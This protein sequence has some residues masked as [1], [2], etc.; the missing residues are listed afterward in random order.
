MSLSRVRPRSFTVA[1][2]C[3]LALAATALSVRTGAAADA[4]AVAF[5][6]RTMG[7]WASLTLVTADSTAVAGLAREGLLSLHHT[8]S[9]MTNWT[10]T[11][12]VARLN[13]AAGGGP[14]VVDREVA[15]VLQLAGEVHA[16]SGGAF[17]VTVEPLVR[18]WGFLGGTPRV[19]APEALTAARTLVGWDRVGFEPATAQLTL[20]AGMRLDLGGI[21]KGYGVD[22]VA[23]RLRAA[24]VS[25]ALVDLT[26]NMAALGSAPGHEG[27]V[28]GIRDPQDRGPYLATIRLRDQCVSTSGDYVQF[29]SRGGQRLGHILDPRTGWPAS[30]LSSAT[31]VAASAAAADAWSTALFVLGPS[32]AR[33]VAGGRDDIAAVLLQPAA[34]DRD[35]LW[36]ESGLLPL[37]TVAPAFVDSLVVRPF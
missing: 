2:A 35:T 16:A 22:R 18:L 17:D 15:A 33:L 25:D 24:G 30:G 23:A 26:G 34:G 1:A 31:V 37:V 12:E 20:P 4:R 32:Q 21:A 19:P 29:V 28:I 11:S 10:S 36:V 7:S 27:W 5:R 14:T 3:L 8:D 6:T 9:L 13:A